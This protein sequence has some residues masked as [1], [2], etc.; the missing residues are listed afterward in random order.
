ARRRAELARLVDQV[1][2]RVQE[3]Y[4]Q[5]RA[6]RQVIELYNQKVLPAARANLKEARA[7]Y[8]NGR[9][10]FSVLSEAQRTLADWRERYL[11]AQ[12]ELYRRQA[13]L[14]R[15][16]GKAPDGLA[17]PPPSA[18]ATGPAAPSGTSP[19]GTSPPPRP[20]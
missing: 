9:V 5:V 20:K 10:P 2:F 19:A 8:T 16:T 18:S 17:G 15:V 13:A 14:D 4:E 3:A 6:A 12:A 7:G 1:G 11:E